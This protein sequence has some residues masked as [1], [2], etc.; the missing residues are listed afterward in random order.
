MSE[1]YYTQNRQQRGPVTEAELKR[2]A[3]SGEL[4]A[5]DLVWREGMAN[6]APAAAASGLFPP[7][8]ATG[9]PTPKPPLVSEPA[10]AQPAPAAAGPPGQATRRLDWDDGPW[11]RHRH[12]GSSFGVKTAIILSAAFAVLLVVG[13][14]VV[15]ILLKP[16]TRR[17]PGTFTLE[18][19]P[20]D[21]SLQHIEFEGGR[22]AHITVTTTELGG[23]ADVDLFVFDDD[24]NEIAF[25]DDPSKDCSVR[26]FVPRTRTLRVEIENLGPG[27][28]R[29]VVTHN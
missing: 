4:R 20:G 27:S 10:V 15:I 9:E 29:C 1:W 14:V 12:R 26:F 25:D 24:G 19:P 13:V 7:A 5:G 2:L 17:G 28:A 23:K 3:E 8:G 22:Q 6:W 11:P 18:L 16:V 21:V